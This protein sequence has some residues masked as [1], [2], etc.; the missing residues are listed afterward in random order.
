MSDRG[1]FL[2]NHDIVPIWDDRYAFYSDAAYSDAGNIVTLENTNRV[3]VL[4]EVMY[5]QDSSVDKHVSFYTCSGMDGSD[6]SLI[7]PVYFRQKDNDGSDTWGALETIADGQFDISDGGHCTSSE[8]YNCFLFEF[9]GEEIWQEGVDGSATARHN[10]CIYAQIVSNAAD[11][12]ADGSDAYSVDL[13]GY[14][15]LGQPG[16]RYSNPASTSFDNRSD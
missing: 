11:E 2:Q 6:A 10:D 5:V 3:A 16:V 1:P 7:E 13:R 15:V 14:Y 4:L 9:D 8:D 12:S